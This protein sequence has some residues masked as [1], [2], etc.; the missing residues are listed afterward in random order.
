MAAE[1]DALNAASGTTAVVHR[2]FQ[3]LKAG[4]L[5]GNRTSGLMDLKFDRIVALLAFCG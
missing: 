5:Q 3:G 4:R 1:L 2:R